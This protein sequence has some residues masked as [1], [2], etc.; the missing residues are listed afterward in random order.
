MLSVVGSTSI[1]GNITQTSVVGF[2]M[3]EFGAVHI[4]EGGNNITS[5]TQMIGTL[6][7]HLALVGD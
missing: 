2:S 3:K 6:L 7:K 5:N 4:V 1:T